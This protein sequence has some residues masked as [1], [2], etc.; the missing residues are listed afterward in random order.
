MENMGKGKDFFTIGEF[1][2]KAGVTLRTLRYYDKIDLLKPTAY[3][4]LG[5]RL[6]TKEDFGNL[7]KIL[8]LKF[9]G[10]SLEEI[11][12]IMK[13]DLISNGF[14]KSLEI[15]K[16]IIEEKAK[17]MKNIVKAIDETLNMVEEEEKVN[18]DKFINI[19]SLIN[20]DKKWIEQYKNSSNLRARI[21]LHQ[22]FST[23]KEG[24]MPWFFKNLPLNEECKVLELGC[25]DGSLW[26]I[27]YNYIPKSWDIYL[28]DFSKGMLEDAKKNLVKQKE[29]FKFEIVDVEKIPYEDESF[30]LVIANHMLYHVEN[31]DRAMSEIKRVLKKDGVFYASTVGKE[32]MKEMREIISK[33]DKNILQVESFNLTEK[34]QLENG[35]KILN[36]W[37]PYVDIKK[38][39]DSL[40]IKEEDALLDY[41]FSMPGNIREKFDGERLKKI[42]TILK[43]EKVQKGYIYITKDT[44]FFKSKKYRGV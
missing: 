40:T 31:I 30:D 14:K 2:K 4:E 36:N 20:E 32:H 1:A 34:F 28:T 22:R 39:E 5:H 17:Q 18:W 27:N 43:K 11:G 6:Y 38:Y 12:D 21:N 8:T 7:Q 10:L 15:Q 35:K 29:R 44:G 13:Y 37:F 24:W 16:E 19:I 9:I 26:R 23:N 33:V 41:I 42:Q 3:N 25:G